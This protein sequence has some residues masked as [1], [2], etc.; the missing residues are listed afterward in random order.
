VQCKT[1]NELK[2][3][4]ATG[5]TGNHKD[6]YIGQGGIDKSIFLATQFWQLY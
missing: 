1:T 3:T 6:L 2:K 5:N 4:Y